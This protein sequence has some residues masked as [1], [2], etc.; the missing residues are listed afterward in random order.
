MRASL[1]FIVSI[2]PLNKLTQPLTVSI[3]SKVSS[4]SSCISLLYARGIPFIVVR[5]LIRAPYTRPVL[6][7]TSSAISGFFFCGIMLEPVLKASS[8]SMNLYSLE[9]HIHISSENL[10]KCIII[11]ERALKNSM[12]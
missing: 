1:N 4:L 10:L 12:T 5:I 2:I 6:P 7:R 11:V 9:F 8:N 3:A